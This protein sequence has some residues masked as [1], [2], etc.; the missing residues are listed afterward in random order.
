VAL[1]TGLLLCSILRVATQDATSSETVAI[2]G[3]GARLDGT[4]GRALAGLDPAFEDWEAEELDQ[5][6]RSSWNELALVLEHSSDGAALHTVVAAGFVATPLRPA[7]LATVFE[8]VVF[9]VEKSPGSAAP[10]SAESLG[11]AAALARGLREHSAPWGDARG[12]HAKIKNVRIH[13]EGEAWRVRSLLLFEGQSAEGS[14][15]IN[16]T[17]SSRWLSGE[18]GTSPLLLELRVESFEEVR[19][20]SP[21][22]PLLADRTAALIAGR[23]EIAAILRPGEDHWRASL[24]HVLGLPLLGHPSGIAIGDVDGDLLEDVYLCQPG[25]IPNQL[26]AHQPDGTVI[27]VAPAAGV[28]FLDFSRAALLLDLDADRDRDLVALLG[29]DLVFLAN[30]GRGRFAE[31]SHRSAPSTTSLAAADGDVDVY[32]CSYKSPYDTDAFPLPYHDANN[33]EPNLLLRNEGDWRFEDATIEL[34]LDGNNRRYSFACAF[35]DFDRDGDQDLCVA[36]D[37]GRKNLYRNDGGRFTDVAAEL[38]V[39]DVSAGMGVAWGDVDRDGWVD[40]H[41]SNMFSSA[42]NRVAYQRRFL[43]EADDGTRS[44]FQRHARGNSLFLNRGDRGFFDAS[45]DAG[46][47]MGR[48]AWGSLFVD[49]NLDGWLDLL[50]ANGLLTQ[51]RSDDL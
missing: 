47:T 22:A 4:A 23:E 8:D 41:F 2:P 32:A 18:R 33:G 21:A 25:G 26:L 28:D 12:F 29:N 40:I 16:S 1:H 30:D 43:A 14:W 42:G 34:G 10:A 45:E 49:L 38:G 11:D 35:E 15:Q 46:I 13:K 24:A 17:W 7:N 44:S 31:R 9:R 37:F 50:V 19:G 48:W 20:S 36:N 3:A 51:E 27:D 6:L 5:L 39:E